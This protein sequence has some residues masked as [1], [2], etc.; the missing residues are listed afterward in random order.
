MKLIA[1]LDE[2]GVEVT[3]LYHD[4]IAVTEPFALL[5]CTFSSLWREGGK[6]RLRNEF[7]D[8]EGFI[9]GEGVRWY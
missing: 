2:T 1:K 6:V 4:G 7:K 3:K 9:L 5:G 8:Q